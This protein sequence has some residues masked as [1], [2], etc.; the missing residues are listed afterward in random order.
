M[1]KD[2]EV[3]RNCTKRTA[4]DSVEV[5]WKC[6]DI[7]KRDIMEYALG[8]QHKGTGKKCTVKPE[9]IKLLFKLVGEGLT[10]RKASIE[11]DL[12]YST[13]Y[14]IYTKGFTS[15]ESNKYVEKIMGEEQ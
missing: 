2:L 1:F 10:I 6:R 5:C 8:I 11:C 7:L 9:K 3:C 12:K 13:A 14:R 4:D 15:D